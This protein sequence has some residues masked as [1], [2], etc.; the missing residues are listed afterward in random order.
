MWLQYI[1]Y[2]TYHVLTD[3][4]DCV[5]FVS[6]LKSLENYRMFGQGPTELEICYTDACNVTSTDS[7]SWLLLLT[8]GAE[9]CGQVHKPY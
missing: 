1:S 7:L 4:E 2:R 8:F 9:P 5:C 6:V 3:V